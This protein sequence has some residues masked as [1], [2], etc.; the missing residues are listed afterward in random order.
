MEKQDVEYRIK[1]A[2]EKLDENHHKLLEKSAHERSITHWLAVDLQEYFPE[3]R[4][5]VEYNRVSNGDKKQYI[6]CYENDGGPIKPEDLEA[7]TVYP[8][9]IVHERG[10]SDRNLLLIE[11]KKSSAGED[12]VDKVECLVKKLNYCFGAYIEVDDQDDRT[13]PEKWLNE[14]RCRDSILSD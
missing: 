2:L 8:D 12:D 7:K 3:H 6:D 4:V 11:I 10:T 5:D 9:I 13:C 1:R 14:L